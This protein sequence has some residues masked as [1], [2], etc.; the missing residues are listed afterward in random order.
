LIE[1]DSKIFIR[2]LLIVK[3]FKII[4]VFFA[5]LCIIITILMILQYVV[6]SKYTF[7]EP[8]AFQGEF[9]YNPYRNID[10][11]KWRR[12]NFH[13][14]ARKFLEQSKGAT[15]SLLILD[16][17]YKSL[18]FNIISISDYQ[19]IDRY[20]SKNKW[21][22]P[23]YE[24]GFQYYK[25]HQLV[26]NANRVNWTDFPFPQ[27]IS[28]EQFV[29]DQLKKNSATIITIV[30]PVY[31]KAYSN[32]DLKYLS[33]YN[34]LEIANHDRLFT[35][36]YDTILSAGHPV[37]IMAGDD[38]HE[39]TNINDVCSSFNLIN[40]DLVRDSI[41]NA[42]STGR[43][44]G[45][46]FNIS[47]FKT[48]E[49]KKAALLDLPEIDA[50]NFKNDTL[51]VCLNKSVKR[52]KF[53]GRHGIEKKSVTDCATGSCFFSIKDTYLRTEIECNDGTIY[54]LNPLF[55][56]NGIRLTYYAPTLNVF[57]TW[58]W[59]SALIF[60]LILISIIWYG[61]RCIKTKK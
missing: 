45:V 5:G 8:Q 3:L 14:H 42:L 22:I 51:T 17:L 36:C 4:K 58:A 7:P 55:R 44:I 46:K 61:K 13:A 30:H 49:E 34:C 59:R 16:S 26:L 38:A 56:F 10:I 2:Q 6:N 9:I 37:F 15:K 28:N 53:I 25:N 29:I 39:W 21:Y 20:E 40:S 50:I 57:K 33:N 48:N 1:F 43:S 47:S 54:F 18:D 31:R 11:T 32:N 60:L 27:T 19:F 52:I 12:A 35:E 24:H 41:L 23:V